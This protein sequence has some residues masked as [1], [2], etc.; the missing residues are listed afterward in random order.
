MGIYISMAL[1]EQPQI[2]PPIEHTY[3]QTQYTHHYKTLQL[4]VPI[5][6]ITHLFW[7]NN[8]WYWSCHCFTFIWNNTVTQIQYAHRLFEQTLISSNSCNEM[9]DIEINECYVPRWNVQWCLIY[10]FHVLQMFVLIKTRS[11]PQ[12]NLLYRLFIYL[13]IYLCAICWRCQHRKPHSHTIMFYLAR[14][15]C[16]FS[17]E[18]NKGLKGSSF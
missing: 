18:S 4:S 10:I 17:W 12:C 9:R 16:L 14:K 6:R 15:L 7:L 13:F 3:T 2:S 8:L 1:S 11:A 5:P